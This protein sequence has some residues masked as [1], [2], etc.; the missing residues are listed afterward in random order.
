MHQ[1][2]RYEISD[3]KQTGTYREQDKIFRT[4]P[5][6][7]HILTHTHTLT[8]THSAL[9]SLRFCDF[10]KKEKNIERI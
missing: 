2:V 1:S 8:A 9:L 5:G 7:P 10:Q 6:T 3:K 4:N